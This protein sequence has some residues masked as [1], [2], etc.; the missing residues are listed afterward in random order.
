M[1]L[2]K[3]KVGERVEVVSL[4]GKE[5]IMKKL[6]SMGIREGCIV[7][8]VQKLGRGM[9]LKVDNSKVAIS[10]ALARGIKVR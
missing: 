6:W 2:D 7:E 3:V 1:M 5:E 10:K 4:E 9:V 8:V